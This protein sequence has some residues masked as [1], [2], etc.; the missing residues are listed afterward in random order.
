[1]ET[2]YGKFNVVSQLVSWEICL[3]ISGFGCCPNSPKFAQDT[4]ILNAVNKLV[5]WEVFLVMFGA[6]FS[7]EKMTLGG[8]QVIFP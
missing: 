7:I 2:I 3:I 8:L 5:S 1:M 6:G 4:N